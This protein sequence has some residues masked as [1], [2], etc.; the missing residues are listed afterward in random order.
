MT[1]DRMYIDGQWVSA[2]SG[3][4]RAVIDPH[5]A[6]VL[7]HVAEGDRADAATAIWVARR[8]FDEGDWPRRPAS[9]R[10]DAVRRLAT[11]VRAHADEL[12]RLETLDTGKTLTESGWDIDDVANVFDYYA[13]LGG[14][15]DEETLT[16]PNP[17]STSRLVREPVG[18]CAQIS[19]WN[20]P[21]LQAS[22]KLAPAL[23]AG[24]TVV[25]KPSEL[26][27]LTTLRLTALAHEVGFPA[28]VINTVLGPGPTVGAALAESP[29][30]DLV[31]FTG[32]VRTGQTIMQA[33]SGNLKRI[34]LELGGK[35]PHIVFDDADLDVAVDHALNAVFFH[36][37]QICSAG[38]RLLLQDGICDAFT[39][40]LVARMQR[41]RL[42]DGLD[43]TT[44]MGPLISAAHR[45][46]VADRVAAAQAEGARLV[47]GGRAPD[48]EALERGFY[49]L[50]TLFTDCEPAMTVVR[51]EIF[52]PVITIER[53][54]SEDE[55]VR[56][57]NDTE[58][59]LS[60]GFRTEDPARIERVSRALRFGTVW[61]NDY[62]VYFAAAPWGGF[63][64]SGI[65][66]ELGRAGLD[67]YTE[68]KHIYESHAPT[69][70]NWF[71]P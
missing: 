68:L 71:G 6:S 17:D 47:L 44:Q 7:T 9:E 42:G 69:A 24:C 2:V 51:E 25:V 40:R 54:S 46:A 28:G 3:A 29:A 14:R 45:A 48:D 1:P 8:A 23:V 13:E 59:G 5:D 62:N 26:T 32:G 37:G 66:R 4:T 50:P 43:P 12:A 21:L 20:Y 61:V 31:S 27:P 65:G 53:F 15:P 64:R 63:K 57:A 41:I 58:Y 19:P 67:E 52:G 34:A 55:A 30:V 11:A 33:A 36:A 10:A 18:V 35:N 56:R 49:Y 60:A 38:A 22:W 39:E 70:L 16:S